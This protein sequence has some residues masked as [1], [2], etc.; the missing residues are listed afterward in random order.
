MIPLVKLAG[1][2]SSTLI[3]TPS[4]K[5]S[6]PTN[7]INFYQP[8]ASQGYRLVVECI[9][10]STKQYFEFDTISSI[11]IDTKSTITTHPMLNGDVAADHIYREPISVSVEG[12][13]S[14]YGS[15]KDTYK[16]GYDRLTNIQKV[17][18]KNK[19]RRCSLFVI[20]D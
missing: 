4:S 7:N 3:K 6:I 14:L 10:D 18:R 1:N 17:F 15:N 5:L 11:S 13:F 12:T 8:K 9:I 20:Y 16:S 2:K 19:K